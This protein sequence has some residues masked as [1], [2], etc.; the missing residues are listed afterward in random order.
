MMKGWLIVYSM[1]IKS[2]KAIMMVMYMS[3]YVGQALK[4]VDLWY[5]SNMIEKYEVFKL[6]EI[7]MFLKPM[8]WAIW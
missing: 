1:F 2:L 3:I 8:F 4:E 7:V 6:L 5:L